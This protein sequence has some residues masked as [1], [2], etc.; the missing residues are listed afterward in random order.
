MKLIVGIGNPG[1]RYAHTRH[2]VGFDVID[3]LAKTHHIRVL[4][5]ACRSLIGQG[6]IAGE[7]TTLAKPQTYVNLSGEAVY[8]LARKL[9]IAD[10]DIL[11]I[12][13]DANLPTGRL[14]IRPR[15]SSGGHKG[16]K[17]IIDRLHTQEFPRIRV[18]IGAMRGDAVG[19]VLSRF[20][21]A[22]RAV[23][24]SAIQAAAEAVEAILREGIEAAMNI[25]NRE[26]DDG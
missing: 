17:S 9:D 4:R 21:R 15:G 24:S 8:E 22:D 18:G 7:P 3:R 14:R 12:Y 6:E 1:R 19:Y 25:Y 23:V 26:P 13:D 16:M 2:N 5:R 10:Q 11:V 20:S